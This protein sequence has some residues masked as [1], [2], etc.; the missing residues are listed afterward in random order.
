MTD[1][2][3]RT[4]REVLERWKAALEPTGADRERGWRGLQAQIPIELGALQP[5]PPHVAA[6]GFKAAAIA[7]WTAIAV[8]SVAVGAGALRWSAS[9]LAPS[10]A[11]GRPAAPTRVVA[12]PA[13]L[14]PADP[15]ATVPAPPP[16]QRV[17][18]AQRQ[19]A[20]AAQPAN[21]AAEAEL[22][23]GARL[24]LQGGATG[25]AAKKLSEHGRLYPRSQ[26][27]AAR[28]LLQVKVLCAQGQPEAARRVAEALRER[29]AGSSEA[30]GL[31]STCAAK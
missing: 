10:A 25:Q 16:L 18:A 27:Y 12:P 30:T 21:L 23:H 5:T 13:T 14:T 9:G 1:E 6:S 26:L 2:Q 15:P 8:L 3:T 19:R 11:P 7:K 24:A 29:A 17:E 22:L 4:S 28:S 31:S 20:P